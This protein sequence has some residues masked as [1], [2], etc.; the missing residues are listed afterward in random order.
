MEGLDPKSLRKFLL[1][2]EGCQAFCTCRTSIKQISIDR[3]SEERLIGKSILTEHCRQI[4]DSLL[5]QPVI[6]DSTGGVGNHLFIIILYKTDYTCTF[7]S[8][9][10]H[11]SGNSDSPRWV[12]SE[13][14]Y[15]LL[16]SDPLQ[17]NRSGKP[18][19]VVL[20]I[21]GLQ[22]LYNRLYSFPQAHPA[23]SFCGKKA[24]PWLFILQQRDQGVP[25]CF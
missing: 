16:I 4:C 22:H 25:S 13:A 21:I 9:K 19:V 10:G 20:F 1:Q 11:H 3:P 14:R 5:N 23:K 2:G 24:D 18:Q 8:A 6:I 15:R 7:E 17:C 12:G